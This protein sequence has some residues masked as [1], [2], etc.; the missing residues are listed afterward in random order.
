MRRY[1]EYRGLSCLHSSCEMTAIGKAL[2]S[3]FQGL[4]YSDKRTGMAPVPRAVGHQN[5][6]GNWMSGSVFLTLGQ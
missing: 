3:A 6:M 4:D 2:L 1:I 5:Q